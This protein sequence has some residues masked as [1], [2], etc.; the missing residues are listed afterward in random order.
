MALPWREHST[1]D[2]KPD[3]AFVYCILFCCILVQS[4]DDLIKVLDLN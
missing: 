4:A 2:R 3:F 1:D